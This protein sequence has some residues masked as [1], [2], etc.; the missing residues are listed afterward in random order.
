M[1]AV[2]GTTRAT[3]PSGTVTLLFTDIEGSTRMLRELGREPYVDALENHRLLLRAAFRGHGGVEVEMQGDSFFYVFPYARQAVAAALAGQRALQDHTWVSQAI[4]VRMGLHTGEPVQ[5]DGIFAGLDIHRAARVMGMARGAQVLLSARTADLVEDDLPQDVALRDLGAYELKD[6]PARQHLFA[7]QGDGLSVEPPA[8]SAP[9]RRPRRARPITLAA[10]ACSTLV[11]LAGLLAVYR[12]TRSGG[13][14]LLAVPNSVA[15][16]DP[17]TDAVAS[18]V[19]VGTTPTSIVAG[20]G[21]IWTLNTGDGTIARM[22]VSTRRV[23]RTV[24]AGYG[25]SD[26]AFSDGQVWVADA[27]ADVARALDSAGRTDAV[28]H[29]GIPHARRRSGASFAAVALAARGDEIW[30]AGGDG[31]TTVVI[32]A[33][34]KRVVR[35]IEGQRAV[36][37]DTSPAGPDIAIGPAGVWATPGT[38]ELLELDSPT[39][40]I[41]QLGGFDGDQGIT[42]VAV[43]SDVW[44]TGA[45]VAW[46]VRP[47]PAQPQGTFAVGQRPTGI[48]LGANSVWTANSVDGTVTRIDLVRGTT[49]TIRVG[50]NPNELIYSNG[51]VWVTVS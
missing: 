38:D 40:S 43:G 23:S 41:V 48:A 12:A 16:I 25:A 19:S 47:A 29:L 8:G 6:F 13:E 17:G 31:L 20:G 26:I 46:Q 35:R 22:D 49:T 24:P 28:V 27:S 11:L 42:S 32:N 34:A 30:A 39:H 33:S 10:A 37:A 44:A 9:Q 21:A 36:D 2:D 1:S 3:L 4:R 50:G 14:A 5:S 15:V 51:L 18:V 7:L 45:G